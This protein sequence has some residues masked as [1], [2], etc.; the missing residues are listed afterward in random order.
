LRLKDV[1]SNVG[2]TSDWFWHIWSLWRCF[3]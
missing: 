3:L 2:E 1:I